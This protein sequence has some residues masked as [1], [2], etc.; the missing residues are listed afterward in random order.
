MIAAVK[1]VTESK[2]IVAGNQQL[3]R[4]VGKIRSARLRSYRFAECSR[5]APPGLSSIARV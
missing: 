1:K 5:Q 3:F 2:G 4:V